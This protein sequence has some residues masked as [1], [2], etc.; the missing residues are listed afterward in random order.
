M[1]LETTECHSGHFPLSPDDVWNYLLITFKGSLTPGR[2]HLAAESE[3]GPTATLSIP[4]DYRV[5]TGTRA[6][7]VRLSSGERGLPSSACMGLPAVLLSCGQRAHG[8][9]RVAACGEAAGTFGG[10]EP[11]PE[12]SGSP[13]AAGAHPRPWCSGASRLGASLPL[14]PYWAP[15]CPVPAA[16]GRPL[17]TGSPKVTSAFPL[18]LPTPALRLHPFQRNPFQP[19]LRASLCPQQG[20]ASLSPGPH[21]DH[22]L[23]SVP[24][25]PGCLHLQTLTPAPLLLPALSWTVPSRKKPT[26]HRPPLRPTGRRQTSPHCGH[27]HRPGHRAP[28]PYP[29][30]PGSRHCPP[31][32]Q[33]SRPILASGTSSLA[34]APTTCSPL[35]WAPAR[36]GS[37]PAREPDP[38]PGEPSPSDLVGSSALLPLC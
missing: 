12:S 25:S 13:L 31:P 26:P 16:G 23:L 1:R 8:W 21:P 9:C 10:Q 34:R 19:S 30:T 22:G 15:A 32:P 4:G 33:D 3:E 17:R 37:S 20:A 38:L 6:M 11:P 14:A 36:P 18:S 2:C 5:L 29:T 24:A 28:P 7:E 27:E 35:P